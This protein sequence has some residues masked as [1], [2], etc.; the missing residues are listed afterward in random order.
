MDVAGAVVVLDSRLQGYCHVRLWHEKPFS[1]KAAA[2]II[3][4]LFLR[5]IGTKDGPA[6]GAL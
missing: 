6:K 3:H 2:D 1:A 4:D 5:G